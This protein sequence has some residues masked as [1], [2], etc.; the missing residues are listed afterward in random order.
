V[1]MRVAERLHAI[2][3]WIEGAPTFGPALRTR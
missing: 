1:R 2:A 3:A